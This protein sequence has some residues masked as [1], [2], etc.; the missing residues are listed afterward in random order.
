M[1]HEKWIKSIGEPKNQ[2]EN[3]PNEESKKWKKI[4][5]TETHSN[6]KVLKKVTQME[7]EKNTERATH[8]FVEITRKKMIDKSS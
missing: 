1:P 4:G 3:K 5:K 7:Y 2:F 6:R 8:R